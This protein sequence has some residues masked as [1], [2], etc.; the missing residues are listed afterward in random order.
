MHSIGH[1]LY[2]LSVCRGGW[3]SSAVDFRLPYEINAGLS[4]GVA[5]P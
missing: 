2:V 3:L 1:S 5:T 4:Y